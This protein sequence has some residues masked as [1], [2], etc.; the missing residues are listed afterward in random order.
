MSTETLLEPLSADAPC[1]VD[2][3]FSSEFDSVQEMRREDD[4][5]LP[6]GEFVT[7]L[8]VADWPGV[9][10]LCE[11]LLQTRTK[12][13]RVAGW[14][15]EAWAQLRG[16]AGLADGLTLVEQLCTRHWAQLQPLP[17]D[18]EQEQRV[19]NLA[20]LLT[21]V[22]NLSQTVPQLSAGTRRIGLRQ[23]EAA[24]ARQQKPAADGGPAPTDGVL[25][26]EDVARIQRDTPREFLLANLADATRALEA[27][28]RL[29]ALVDHLLGA[30]GPGFAAARKA[31]ENA[32]HAA[33]RH[34]RA[35]GA[36]EAGDAAGPDV[37]GE[38]GV[39]PVARVAAS[40]DAGPPQTR[41]QAL[42]QLRVVAD[43]FR[44]TEPHSPVAYLADKAA[45]WGEM[46]LHTWL[47]AVVKDGAALSQLE[48]MLGVEAP[49]GDMA[50]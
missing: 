46:P 34:A 37:S 20:W 14:L 45:R 12:D 6:Q 8:K 30:E 4:P 49:K 26:M 38:A 50:G 42:Q 2:M 18:G 24:R 48:E 3:S 31:L 23:I 9:A 21:R 7:D 35:G 17:E 32:V 41:A 5:T 1:G 27:L 44:R 19:G 39:A 10:A 22:E 40:G 36:L 16:F 25:T 29:Q 43:F 47:R 33:K 28:S 15:V 11:R 13:L